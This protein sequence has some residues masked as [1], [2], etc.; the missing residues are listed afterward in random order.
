MEFVTNGTDQFIVVTHLHAYYTYNC[1][2]SAATA[3]GSGPSG[4][5]VVRTLEKRMAARN[6]TTAV[7]LLIT[8]L[9]RVDE[10]TIKLQ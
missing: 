9:T 1:S 3:I 5:A 10:Y 4:L 7:S 2:V 6:E 8:V